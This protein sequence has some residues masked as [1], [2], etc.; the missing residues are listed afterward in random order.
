METIKKEPKLYSF[1]FI[2][3]NKKVTYH[4]IIGNSKI[5]VLGKLTIIGTILDLDTSGELKIR[6]ELP[7]RDLIRDL[8]ANP[9]T[10][11]LL[12]EELKNDFVSQPAKTGDR[13]TPKDTVSS[14]QT[15]VYSLQLAKDRYIATPQD[16]KVV[17]RILN[18]ISPKTGMKPKKKGK[19]GC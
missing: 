19:K 6:T 15:F 7:V 17:E 2:H 13:P 9:D 18:K 5:D 10:N 12:Q 1:E 8:R 4:T 14:L 3:S 16:K 11:S